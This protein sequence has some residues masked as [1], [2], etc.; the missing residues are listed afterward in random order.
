MYPCKSVLPVVYACAYEGFT[1]DYEIHFLYQ[2]EILL[3]IFILL[4]LHF[5]DTEVI[6]CF[7]VFVLHHFSN[8]KSQDLDSPEEQII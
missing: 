6:Y 7:T 2:S 5:S 8:S 3:W 4:F 1:P